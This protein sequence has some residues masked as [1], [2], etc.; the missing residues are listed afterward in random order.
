MLTRPGVVTTAVSVALV[1]AGR[2]LAIFELFVVGAGG[3]A[4]V[5]GAVLLTALTRLRLDVVRTLQPPRLHAGTQA[6]VALSVTNRSSRRTPVL[7]LRDPVGG[8]RSAS[9]MLAPLAPGERVDA[10]YALPGERRGYIDIGP[11]VVRLSDPFGLAAASATA[12]PVAALVVWPAIDTVLAPPVTA[13]AQQALASR[14]VPSA[15]GGEFYALRPYADGDDLRRVHWRASARRDDLVVRQDEQAGQ[16]QVT[17]ILDTL[18]GAY[19]QEAFE[20]AVSAAASIAVAAE[21]DGLDVRLVTTAGYDSHATPPGVIGGG[22]GAIL[23]HLALVELRQMGHLSTVVSAMQRGDGDVVVVTGDAGAS[24]ALT[25]PTPRTPAPL[26]VVFGGAATGQPASSALRV[27]VVDE[28]TTFP[29]AWN[30][31]VSRRRTPSGV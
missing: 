18:A 29:A 2:M 13:G 10:T 6:S 4:L 25:S 3:A 30:H 9:V 17:V 14:A 15:D 22:I 11:L 21:R 20:P 7:Q 1:V 19:R 5:I 31:L 24:D 23:D 8:H 26:L 16:V 12:A 28:T 27:V